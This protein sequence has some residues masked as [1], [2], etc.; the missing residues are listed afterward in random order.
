VPA[1]LVLS[2]SRL[3]PHVNSLSSKTAPH[4][5][6]KQLLDSSSLSYAK[7]ALFSLPCLLAAWSST[8]FFVFLLLLFLLAGFSLFPLLVS[9]SHAWFAA[10]LLHIAA[11]CEISH[12]HTHAQLSFSRSLSHV[13]WLVDSH[14]A[15]CLFL[16]SSCRFPTP[17]TFYLGPISLSHVCCPTAPIFLSLSH[18]HATVL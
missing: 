12:S 17:C 14:L 1:A 16:F 18:S 15:P 8:C 4:F 13:C 9:P 5:M 6:P 3:D 10:V 2:L 11:S 7:T